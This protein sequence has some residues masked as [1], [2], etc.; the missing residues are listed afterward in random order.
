[1]F[2]HL[3]WYGWMSLGFGS[4]AYL[5]CH[6]IRHWVHWLIIQAL[7]CLI[8]FLHKTD[9]KYKAATPRVKPTTTPLI[10]NKG[11]IGVSEGDLSQ[12]LSK[13]PDL[14]IERR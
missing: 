14:T 5:H 4:G 9:P 8:W 12:W 7:K 2:E 6:L 3:T 11:G 10:K 1:M 13:N